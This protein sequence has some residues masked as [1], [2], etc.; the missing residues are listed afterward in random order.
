MGV[1]CLGAS[2]C[3]PCCEG[4]RSGDE[5]DLLTFPCCCCSGLGVG[6]CSLGAGGLGL[7]A[8]GWFEG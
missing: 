1:M 6:D 3:C 8:G 5:A 2:E 4:C 7:G